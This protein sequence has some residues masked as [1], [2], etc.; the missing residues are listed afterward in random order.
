MKSAGRR[1]LKRFLAAL[2][3][4]AYLV[5]TAP[6]YRPERAECLIRNRQMPSV[7]LL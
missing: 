6:G 5:I 1:G 2:R 4:R 3:G 7:W